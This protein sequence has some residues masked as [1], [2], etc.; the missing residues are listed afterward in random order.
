MLVIL[1]IMITIYFLRWLFNLGDGILTSGLINYSFLPV[2]QGF[3]NQ[4]ENYLYEIHNHT[5]LTDSWD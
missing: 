3:V 2:N 5:V 4:K 1:A